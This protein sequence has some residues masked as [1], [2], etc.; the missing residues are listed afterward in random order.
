MGTN[1]AAEGNEFGTSPASCNMSKDAKVAGC[2]LTYF[3]HSAYAGD[4]G[5]TSYG[6]SNVKDRSDAT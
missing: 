2:N 4:D 1:V 5:R 6:Y 3:H